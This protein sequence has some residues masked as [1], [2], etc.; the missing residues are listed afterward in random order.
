MRIREKL[1]AA[2]VIA[3]SLTLAGYAVPANAVEEETGQITCSTGRTATLKTQDTGRWYEHR[4]GYQ[5]GAIVNQANGNFLNTIHTSNYGGGTSYFY[6]AA[7]VSN[8]VYLWGCY[9]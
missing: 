5:G 1:L 4:R 3:G 2:A 9:S 8:S 6:A 7:E